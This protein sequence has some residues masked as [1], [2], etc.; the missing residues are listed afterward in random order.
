MKFDPELEKLINDY[1]K[2]FEISGQRIEAVLPSVIQAGT[3]SR[4]LAFS[5][6]DSQSIDD[7][8]KI[9]NV[10]LIGFDV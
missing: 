5:A 4:L 7:E 6:E 3:D 10:L 2:R 8:E 9:I 1:R